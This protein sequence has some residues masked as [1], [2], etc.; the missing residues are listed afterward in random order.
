MIYRACRYCYSLLAAP[1]VVRSGRRRPSICLSVRL[2]SLARTSI[3]VIIL[4]GHVNPG[5]DE[6]TETTRSALSSSRPAA[7]VV[8]VGYCVGKTLRPATTIAAAAAT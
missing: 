4:I 2:S 5:S 3:R 7:G 8:A 1:A 6:D